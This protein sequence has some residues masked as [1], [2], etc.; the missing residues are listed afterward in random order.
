VPKEWL[1]VSPLPCYEDPYPFLRD[2]D[3]NIPIRI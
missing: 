3:I 1:P 2:F